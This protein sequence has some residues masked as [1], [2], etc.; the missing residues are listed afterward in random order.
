MGEAYRTGKGVAKDLPKAAELLARSCDMGCGYGCTN[1][2]KMVRK[3]QGGLAKDEA[4]AD[5]LL[6]KGCATGDATAC[7]Q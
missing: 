1:L 4:R 7:P 3:G 2:A 5:A 6:Q